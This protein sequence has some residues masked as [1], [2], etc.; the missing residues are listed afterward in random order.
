[1]KSA[2]VALSAFPVNLV[3][4]PD[5]KSRTRSLRL[6]VSF[7][8]ASFGIVIASSSFE[9]VIV[10]IST[11]QKSGRPVSRAPSRNQ[12]NSLL[13]QLYQSGFLRPRTLLPKL[14]NLQRRLFLICCYRRSEEHTS[15]LQ[16]H[17]E[18]VCR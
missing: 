15:E 6:F 11:P 3:S 1:M 18:L 9:F 4:I 13:P 7:G 16:S 8:A 5:S 12:T 14:V 17:S 10:A 2:T